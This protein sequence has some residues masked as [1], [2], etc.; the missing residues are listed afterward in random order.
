MQSEENLVLRAKNRDV[1]AFA[2]LYE[3]HF[4][5]IFRYIILRVGNHAEAEELTQDVF[6]KAFQSIISYEWRQIPFSSWLYRIARNQVIDFVRRNR[7][8]NTTTL[9]EQISA[10]VDDPVELAE[11]WM[12]IKEVS[13]AISHLTEAQ[14]EVVALR[15]SSGLSTAEA[16]HILGKSE[17]AIKALQHSALVSMRKLFK[18]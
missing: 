6:V 10:G 5:S 7:K 12:K 8:V 4:N 2:L 3:N 11:K 9:D 15:F 16:A 18:E 17:G 1:E 14:Q 13:A